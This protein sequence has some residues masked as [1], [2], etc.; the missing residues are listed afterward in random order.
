MLH[1]TDDARVRLLTLERPDARNALDT[2]HY[3]ALADA[4]DDTADRADLAVV[5]IT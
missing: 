1:V 4:L 5:I 3:H 2:E